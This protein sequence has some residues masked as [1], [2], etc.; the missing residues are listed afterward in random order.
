MM[1]NCRFFVLPLCA[2]A[3]FHMDIQFTQNLFL[4]RLFSPLQCYLYLKQKSTYVWVLLKTLYSVPLYHLSIFAPILH[5]LNYY[6]FIISLDN[7][8]LQG[9]LY[10][11]SFN[12]VPFLTDCVGHSWYFVF[13]LNFGICLLFFTLPKKLA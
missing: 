12:F 11:N 4:E 9:L 6:N 8:N 2:W 5:F 1:I 13:C 3:K 7:F 10:I